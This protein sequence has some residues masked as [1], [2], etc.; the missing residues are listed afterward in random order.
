MLLISLAALALIAAGCKK[1]QPKEEPT[2][3]TEEVK[4]EGVKTEEVKTEEV[5]TEGA[6]EAEAEAEETEAAG[7]G[8]AEE[9]CGALYDTMKELVAQ[10][11]KR[12]GKGKKAGSG[13][14]MPPRD[15]FVTA[16]QEL[17]ADVVRCMNPKVAMKEQA[18]CAEVMQNA[19]KAKVER[20][21]K[22]IGGKK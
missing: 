20:F 10:M 9:H 13:K 6:E 4:T 2:A 5:K 12:F 16:C 15:K 22:I 18:K 3:T 1:D 7:E 17:P 21:Q 14:E 11:E 19:D 8:A